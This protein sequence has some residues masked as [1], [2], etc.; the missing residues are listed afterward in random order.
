M[1]MALYSAFETWHVNAKAKRRAEDVCTRV[2]LRWHNQT[3][4]HAFDTWHDHSSKQR[5]I[6]TIG[7]R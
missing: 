4:C 7:R 5:R 6:E 1:N 3:L 2:I